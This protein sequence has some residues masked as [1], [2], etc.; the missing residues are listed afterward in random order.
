MKKT[1]T[2]AVCMVMMLVLLT[3]CSGNTLA[4]TWK[5]TD[6]QGVGLQGLE[7]EMLEMAEAFG[8]SVI[9]K[10]D[11]KTMTLTAEIFGM[12]Q[13]QSDAYQIKGSTITLNSGSTLT[14]ELQGDTLKL[15]DG[16]S[17]ITLT[18]IK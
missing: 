18:K 17:S 16:Q 6:A 3:G 13:S 10:F 4:G 7:T 2:L 12:A 5:L 14:F 11:G 8:G 15:T 9:M 1:L